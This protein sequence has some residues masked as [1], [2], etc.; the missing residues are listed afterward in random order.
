MTMPSK[1]LLKSCLNFK[2]VYPRLARIHFDHSQ[3]RIQIVDFFAFS[4]G[5]TGG[6]ETFRPHVQGGLPWINFIFFFFFFVFCDV[7]WT[8]SIF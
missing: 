4:I 8:F 7:V 6:S 3:K 5:P 2:V 1:M